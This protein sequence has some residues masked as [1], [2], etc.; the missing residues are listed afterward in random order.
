MPYCSEAARKFWQKACNFHRGRD[1]DHICGNP[2]AC[3]KRIREAE[4]AEKIWVLFQ[5][6]WE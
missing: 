2:A 5:K 1:P 3:E 4:C 6:C